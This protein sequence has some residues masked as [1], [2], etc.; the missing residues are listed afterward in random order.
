VYIRIGNLISSMTT[1]IQYPYL[2]GGVI[3]ESCHDSEKEK[4]ENEEPA[5][6]IYPARGPNR[7]SVLYTGS[8]IDLSPHADSASGS[9]TSWLC[10][11]TRG[12][13][14][15]SLFNSRCPKA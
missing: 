8:T 5:S 12:A 10:C 1:S 13:S 7:L 11:A 9:R 14:R 3:S 4:K 2:H 15:L 6:R